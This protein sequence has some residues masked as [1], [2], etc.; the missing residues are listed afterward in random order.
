MRARVQPDPVTHVAVED[1]RAA[2]DHA[3]RKPVAQLTLVR[4]E[5]DDVED[6]RLAD[7]RG[8]A[9]HGNPLVV[10][11]RFHDDIGK[12]PHGSFG[13]FRQPVSLVASSI[14]HAASMSNGNADTA[15]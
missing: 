5:Q 1:D 13:R 3:H 14:G 8:L 4:V 12:Q 2:V 15:G 10:S 9:A 11:V 6:Q 7:N